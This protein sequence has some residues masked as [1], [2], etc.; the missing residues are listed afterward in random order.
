MIRASAWLLAAV[1]A[2]ACAPASAAGWKAGAS[3]V[4]ITPSDP[5]WMA[6]YGNR[7]K[8]SEGKLHDL[9]VKSLSIQ[10]VDGNPVVLVS[11]DV[12]GISRPFLNE[13]RDALKQKC[14]LT[15]DRI[16]LACSHTHSGPVVGSNL[17][18]MYPMNDDQRERTK[19]YAAY[20]RDRVIESVGKALDALEPAEISWGTGRCD[21]AVNR[22]NNNQARVPEIRSA[23]Q[24]QGP[25]DH[26]V[27]VLKVCRANGSLLSVVYGYACHCTT[28][29][30]YEL[31]ND[32]AGYAS[33]AIE[34]AHPG[35]TSLFVAGCGADQNPLPRTTVE[36]AERY[37]AMMAQSVEHVI[38]GP[39]R[40]VSGRLDASYEEID[41]DLGT[42]P[43]KAHWADEAKSST[44]AVANRAKMLLAKIES[45]GSLARTYP[46]P[47]QVWRLG[48]DL[49]W[50]LLGGEVVVDY[51][52]RLKR[53]LGSS[54]TWVSAYCNDVMAYIPSLR[55]LKEGGYE[56]ATAMIY[57]GLPCP[58]SERVEEQIVESVRKLTTAKAK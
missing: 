18:T 20:L 33:L 52:L 40:P 49:T 45:D 46:Y 54:H 38:S 3:A 55:V 15:R 1:L 56:G 5:I 57:Y 9:W 7:T 11:L 37:G 22:R 10:D 6:G 34:K 4:V 51:S 23:L 19:T 27:P 14:G 44:L 21:F 31:S 26:D 29:Q 36:L 24:L 35:A 30:G 2:G 39:L 17:I 48:D 12:C 58:W 41:L 28:L 8:P 25:V 43:D 32:W 16:S 42:V 47:I 53:N 13:V 50:V